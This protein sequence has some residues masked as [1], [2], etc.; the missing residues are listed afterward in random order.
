NKINAQDNEQARVALLAKVLLPLATTESERDLRLRQ[1]AD[2]AG[3]KAS[4][5]ELQ[6]Q[7]D[8]AFNKAA[9]PKFTV[10]TAEGPSS[11]RDREY[12]E[13]RQAIAH[14]LFSM[15]DVLR[16]DENPQQPPDLLDSKAY[17]R[18][19][20]VVG[21][22]AMAREADNQ[23]AILGR[24]SRDVLAGIDRDRTAFVAAQHRQLALIEALSE[25]LDRQVGY[26]TD[27]AE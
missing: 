14:L 1:I 24:M 4:T 18:T 12:D 26:L 25:Q 7:V 5:S 8:D 27:Q 13:K 15:D 19:L 2:P 22:P 23:S 10:Q 20:A 11:Q 21:L 6:E 16:E 17:E 3:S 9:G